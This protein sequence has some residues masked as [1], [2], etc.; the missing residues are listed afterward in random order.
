M[1]QKE[2]Y[3]K[4]V[5]K[6]ENKSNELLPYSKITRILKLATDKKFSKESVQLIQHS[7]TNFVKE[8]S[9]LSEKQSRIRSKK[10]DKDQSVTIQKEDVIAAIQKELH[11]IDI[12]FK[13]INH[14]FSF[15]TM[16]DSHEIFMEDI[17]LLPGW[18]LRNLSLMREID[19]KSNDIQITLKERRNKY[20]DDLCKRAD[21]NSQNI[22]EDAKISKINEINELQ[23]ELRAL[24]KEKIAISD[25]SVHYI[26]YDGE[27]LKKHYEQLRESLA[28][29]YM[30]NNESNS[31]SNYSGRVSFQGQVNFRNSSTGN[32]IHNIANDL[33]N[34][35]SHTNR[36]S[37]SAAG[38]SNHWNDESQTEEQNSGPTN[39]SSF[40]NDSSNRASKRR[41]SSNTTHVKDAVDQISKSINNHVDTSNDLKTDQLTSLNN[42]KNKLCSTCEGI[43]L[44]SNKFVQCEYCLNQIHITCSWS[45]DPYLCRKCCKKRSVQ[46]SSTYDIE[47]SVSLLNTPKSDSTKI[48]KSS[49]KK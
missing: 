47:Y 20:L 49:R 33:N 37:I 46:P 34:H 21:L 24:L 38:N 32:A 9:K 44:I 39:K 23:R 27:I 40:T 15:I 26:R 43:E 28:E 29:N 14:C 3:E 13:E 25:Q 16:S 10:A 12:R 45:N 31:S 7:I 17:S 19:K 1:I 30:N 18:I 8:I 35:D 42:N 11:S 6:Q 5:Y 48:S 36:N 2:I 22:D 4:T 41:R